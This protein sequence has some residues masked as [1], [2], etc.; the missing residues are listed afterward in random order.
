MPAKVQST[1]TTDMF[2]ISASLYDKRGGIKLI[3]PKVNSRRN[4]FKIFSLSGGQNL[5][6]T[7]DICEEYKSVFRV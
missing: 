5:E 2:S 3:Q 1:Y 7:T 4:C 6:R